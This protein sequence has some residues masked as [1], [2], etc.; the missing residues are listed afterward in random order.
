MRL[1]RD[2]DAERTT[3]IE[4]AEIPVRTMMGDIYT[5]RFSGGS[6]AWVDSGGALRVGPESADAD[7]SSAHYQKGRNHPTVTDDNIARLPV[8][9]MAVCEPV[10]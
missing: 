10:K 4:I 2:G 5:I 1:I 8:E 9:I 7:L 6:A 3:D